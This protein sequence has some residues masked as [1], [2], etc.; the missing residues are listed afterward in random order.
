MA[1][2]RESRKR[3]QLDQ[4]LRQAL[5]AAWR[6]QIRL[7]DIKDGRLVFLAPS[8]AWASRL[9]L[10]QTQILAA[11]RAGGVPARSLSVKVVPPVAATVPEPPPLV[12]LSSATAN[13]LRAAAHSLSDPELR[14]LFLALA[15]VADAANSPRETD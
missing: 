9:R 2:A 6:D 13:H 3:D 15:S 8:S 1:L 14:D 12:P 4:H 11:A 10:A 5:P 7:A